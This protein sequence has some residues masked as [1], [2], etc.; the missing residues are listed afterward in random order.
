MS[1]C[2]G[3]GEFER[4]CPNEPNGKNKNPYFCDRCDKLRIDHISKR[5][6]EIEKRLHQEVTK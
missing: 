4:K 3:F 2:Y 1:K 5:L 6:D